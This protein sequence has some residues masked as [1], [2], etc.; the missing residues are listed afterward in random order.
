MHK[1]QDTTCI[2]RIDCAHHAQAL[3]ATITPPLIQTYPMRL[4]IACASSVGTKHLVT[5][6]WNRVLWQVVKSVT[7][8]AKLTVRCV[9]VWMGGM[10]CI[11]MGCV[12]VFRYL[13]KNILSVAIQGNFTGLGFWGLGF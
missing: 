10:C 12:G 9:C 6:L 8:V 1:Q 3:K 5:P 4:A 11:D 2:Q 13:H 7:T